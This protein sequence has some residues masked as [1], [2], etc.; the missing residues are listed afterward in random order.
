MLVSV[1]PQVNV[2]TGIMHNSLNSYVQ[3]R[4]QTTKVHPQNIEWKYCDD[5]RFV[6]LPAMHHTRN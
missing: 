5:D 1:E 2:F 4:N 6:S 3:L